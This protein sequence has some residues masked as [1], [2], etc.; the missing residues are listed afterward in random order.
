VKKTLGV[1][2]GTFTSIGFEGLVEDVLQNGV[3]ETKG[4]NGIHGMNEAIKNGIKETKLGAPDNRDYFIEDAIQNGV[5]HTEPGGYLGSIEMK[6]KIVHQLES[7][8]QN[9]EV[10]GVIQHGVMETF[11]ETHRRRQ[12]VVQTIKNGIKETYG[13]EYHHRDTIDGVIK[14][15]IKE[16]IL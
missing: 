5:K 4:I 16:T 1:E 2:D 12:K 8:K 13:E 14:N 11:P 15:G 7:P 6:G 3:K 10:E 9:D